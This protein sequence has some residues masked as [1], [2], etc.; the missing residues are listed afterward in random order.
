M[1]NL[2][3]NRSTI[4]V[5]DSVQKTV[6]MPRAA[7]W[8]LFNI[9]S[10]IL[11]VYQCSQPAV[12]GLQHE[13]SDASCAETSR[14]SGWCSQLA[15]RNRVEFDSGEEFENLLQNEI[16]SELNTSY[17]RF[18]VWG[19]PKN[20]GYCPTNRAAEKSAEEA[21][22]MAFLC[23]VRSPDC[24]SLFHEENWAE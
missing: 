13:R 1:E 22:N 19:D 17:L 15:A 11:C 14:R 3:H 9:L 24:R 8:R 21:I 6:E 7:G 18:S 10:R 16:A 4:V 2:D 5:V 20:L 23:R 12:P